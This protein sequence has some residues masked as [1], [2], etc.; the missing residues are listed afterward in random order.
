VYSLYH[1]LVWVVCHY[2]HGTVAIF[3]RP[4][5]SSKT[6]HLPTHNI[7]G[8]ACETPSNT[9]TTMIT[10]LKRGQ[11]LL[12]RHLSTAPPPLP[13]PPPIADR[14]VVVTGLGAVT[15]F[16][17]LQP[18]W[19]ALLAGKTATRTSTQLASSDLALPT[20]VVASIPDSFDPAPYLTNARAQSVPFIALALAAATEALQDAVVRSARAPWHC[21]PLV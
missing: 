18:T 8:D 19:E 16:G 15:P 5:G 17:H 11:Q 14:R 1:F 21:V 9:Q 13:R 20:H 6:C 12:L 10:H 7:H 2:Y 3:V 4:A